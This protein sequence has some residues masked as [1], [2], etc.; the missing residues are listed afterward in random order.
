MLQ[1]NDKMGHPL[2]RIEK[3]HPFWNKKSI[4]IGSLSSSGGPKGAM[5]SFVGTR[6]NDLTQHWSDFTKI[7]KK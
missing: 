2:Y 1:I 5:T 6:T 4:A 7:E 3:Q